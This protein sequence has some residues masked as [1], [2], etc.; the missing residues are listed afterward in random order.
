MY[1]YVSPYITALQIFHSDHRKEFGIFFFFKYALHS[2]FL[3][4]SSPCINLS[5]DFILDYI[6]LFIIIRNVNIK[7]I[8]GNS[9]RMDASLR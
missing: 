5:M 3:F 6:I 4:F 9:D 8:L 1:P 2:Y 7:N